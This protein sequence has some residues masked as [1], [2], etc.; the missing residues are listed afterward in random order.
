MKE[1]FV[2][3]TPR[4]L[5]LNGFMLNLIAGSGVYYQKIK[6]IPNLNDVERNSMVTV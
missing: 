4:D 2:L 1:C 6:P 3:K 5:C